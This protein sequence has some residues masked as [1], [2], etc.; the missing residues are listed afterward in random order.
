MDIEKIR[1]ILEYSSATILSV[2]SFAER[3]DVV[4]DILDKA[5]PNTSALAAIYGPITSMTDFYVKNRN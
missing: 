3:I 1:A 4:C 5:F 2:Y